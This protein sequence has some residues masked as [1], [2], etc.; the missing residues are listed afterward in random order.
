MQQSQVQQPAAPKVK[1][2]P[3]IL[4]RNAPVSSC[5]PTQAA[6]V[7]HAEL[8][9]PLTI[10][11]SQKVEPVTVPVAPKVT[12]PVTPNLT[13][14]KVTVPVSRPVPKPS[15]SQPQ[16]QSKS[17]EPPKILSKSKDQPLV[18]TNTEPLAQRKPR[19]PYIKPEDRSSEI[20]IAKPASTIET[21][22]S[23]VEPA[24]QTKQR[25][26][27]IR[28]EDRVPTQTNT[29]FLVDQQFERLKAVETPSNAAEANSLVFVEAK[30][31]KLE[32][33]Y[34]ENAPAHYKA[35]VLALEATSKKIEAAIKASER[36]LAESKKL[37]EKNSCTEILGNYS[38]LI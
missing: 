32:D 34:T 31:V 20:L 25:E 23:T 7:V 13:T 14:P 29:N 27:S 16:P 37:Q 9:K 28:P 33:G 30:Q 1:G 35:S 19:E 17:Q 11:I 2:V 15:Q 5:Q 6:P 8:P 10:L 36:K 18:R 22:K 38:Q 24:P 26:P 3:K 4:T 21:A 12:A